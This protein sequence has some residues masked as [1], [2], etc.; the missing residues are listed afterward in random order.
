MEGIVVHPAAVRIATV[1]G[2]RFDTVLN[3]GIA[4]NTD[5]VRLAV[6][7]ARVVLTTVRKKSAVANSTGRAG[8]LEWAVPATAVGSD[9]AADTEVLLAEHW[10]PVR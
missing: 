10:H 7:S 2:I 3:F 1:P 8:Y 6:H 4:R 9:I 5:S